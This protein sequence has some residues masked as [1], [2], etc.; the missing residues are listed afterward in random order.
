MGAIVELLR[1]CGRIYK[2]FLTYTGYLLTV[3]ERAHPD[4]QQRASD[5]RGSSHPRI[6][7]STVSTFLFVDTGSV[8]VNAYA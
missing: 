6:L 5:L 2:M 8:S 4:K 1:F 7:N 3:T